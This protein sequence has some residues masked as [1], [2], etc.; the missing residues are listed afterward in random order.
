MYAGID[1]DTKHKIE[2]LP[3]RIKVAKRF[4]ENNLTVFFRKGTGLFMRGVSENHKAPAEMLFEDALPL[5]RCELQ[6]PALPLSSTFWGNYSVIKEFKEKP[7]VAG[8]DISLE[9]KAYYILKTLLADTSGRYKHFND[10][11]VNLME[12]LEDYKTLSDY[13]LR[14]LANLDSGS[15]DPH[16]IE[17]VKAELTKL[18]HELGAHYLDE[19]KQRSEQIDKEIIV[20]VENIKEQAS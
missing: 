7:G 3:S 8:S 19:V 14:R 1:D 20:A 17:G 2:R 5:I 6:E 12:D 16:K 11:L 15:D 9:K 18:T 4:G 13:T 10:F